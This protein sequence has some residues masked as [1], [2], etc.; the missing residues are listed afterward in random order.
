MTSAGHPVAPG[1]CLLFFMQ[2]GKKKPKVMYPQIFLAP[3][4]KML[5]AIK[6]LIHCYEKELD[7][8]EAKI[9]FFSP[10]VTVMS[11]TIFSMIT[12]ILILKTWMISR[13]FSRPLQC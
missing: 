7:K 9:M 1:D 8:D 13:I 12:I 4:Q 11:G 3:F 10:F 6:L 2:S 5:H